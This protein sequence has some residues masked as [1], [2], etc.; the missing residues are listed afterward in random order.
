MNR[1]TTTIFLE[2]VR[3]CLLKG[4]FRCGPWLLGSRE[5]NVLCKPESQ[6]FKL[7]GSKIRFLEVGP[8][9][10]DGLLPCLSLDNTYIFPGNGAAQLDCQAPDC[11][12]CGT[13]MLAT[14]TDSRSRIIAAE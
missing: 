13:D 6:M 5:P 4:K 7:K 12:L 8:Q 2:S 10:K 11:Q 1:S 14:Q 9:G 3:F